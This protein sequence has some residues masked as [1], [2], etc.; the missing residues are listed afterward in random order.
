MQRD[1]TNM[2]SIA[3]RLSDGNEAVCP[4]PESTFS[5][6]RSCSVPDAEA[7]ALSLHSAQRAAL[8]HFCYN[9]QHLRD[10]ALAII[11]SCSLEDLSP[12]FGGITDV[13]M[14]QAKEALKTRSKGSGLSISLSH[15]RR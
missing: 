3:R 11:R 1:I 8:A 9:K 15:G 5:K 14:V 12:H 6:L 2:P 7:I 10:L 4:V 13:V